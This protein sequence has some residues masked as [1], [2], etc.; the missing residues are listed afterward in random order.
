MISS[1][2]SVFLC[3]IFLTMLVISIFLFFSSNSVI[4]KYF[5]LS[6]NVISTAVFLF[7]VVFYSA[8]PTYNDN[9]IENGALWSKCQL[10]EE[11]FYGEKLKKMNCDGVIMNIPS[12]LYSKSVHAYTQEGVKKSEIKK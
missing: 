2:E 11:N 7:L 3:V 4:K 5:P 12:T 10:I 8:I 1:R 6:L 9:D